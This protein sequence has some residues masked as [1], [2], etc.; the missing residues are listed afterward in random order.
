MKRR[1][2]VIGIILAAILAFASLGFAAWNMMIDHG[3]TE[4]NFTAYT[5]IDLE[6][7]ADTSIRAFDYK[8]TGFVGENQYITSFSVIFD[9]KEKSEEYSVIITLD[10]EDNFIPSSGVSIT[11]NGNTINNTKSITL[12]GINSDRLVTITYTITTQATDWSETGPIYMALDAGKII[13]L[14]ANATSSNGTWTITKKIELITTFFNFIQISMPEQDTTVY[15]YNGAQQT[16]AVPSSSGYTVTNNVRTDA[17]TQTVVISLNDG[18]MWSDETLDDLEYTFVINPSIITITADNKTATYGDSAPTYTYTQS[19]SLYG[20]DTLPSI[21]IDNLSCTCTYKK[22]DAAQNYVIEFASIQ[23]SINSNYQ[24][25]YVNGQLLVDPLSIGSN[26]YP[27]NDFFFT[28][29]DDE[30]TYN[31]TY[32]SPSISISYNDQL[33]TTTQKE[34]L[35]VNYLNNKNAGQ[36]TITITGSGNYA[37]LRTFNFTINKANISIIKTTNNDLSFKS[38][39]RSWDSIKSSIGDILTFD[40]VISGDIVNIAVNGMHNG[41]FAYGKN[42][43]NTNLA[44]TKY[45]SE[46]LVS[47]TNVVGS[48]YLVY[49]SISGSSSSNYNLLTPTIVIKYKTVLV[50]SASF[51]DSS[52]FYTIEDAIAQ[53]SAIYFPGDS[54]GTSSYVYSSFCALNNNDRPNET[55]YN[56]YNSDSKL[57]E[58]ALSKK[59]LVPYKQSTNEK[60]TVNSAA[61]GNVY[62]ALYIPKVISVTFNSGGSL[63]AAAY[64]GGNQSVTETQVGNR[65]VIMNDGLLVFNSNSTMTSY[66]FTMGNGE[67]VLNNSSTAMDCLSVFDWPGGSAASNSEFHSNCFPMAAY[68]VHNIACK[69]II[70]SGAVYQ[71][72]FSFVISVVGPKSVTLTILGTTNS[73][74]LFKPTA[75]NSANYVIKTTENVVHQ[76]TRNLQTKANKEIDIIEIHGSYVDSVLSASLYGITLSSGPSKSMP[77][78]RMRVEIAENSEL[79]LITSDYLFLPGTY[80]KVDNNATLII[81]SGSNDIDVAFV[82]KDSPGVSEKFISYAASNDDAYLLNN[83]KVIV[84]TSASIGGTIKTN[85]VGAILDIQSGGVTADY[86]VSISK[87][88]SAPFYESGSVSANGKTKESDNSLLSPTKYIAIDY[89]NDVCWSTAESSLIYTIEYYDSDKT[90]LIRSVTLSD[91]GVSK[92]INYSDLDSAYKLGYTFDKWYCMSNDTEF[93]QEIVEN[94]D[95]LQLYASWNLTS[96]SINYLFIRFANYPPSG[97]E[98][99]ILVEDGVINPNVNSFSIL[100]GDGTPIDSI[101]FAAASYSEKNQNYIAVNWLKITNVSELNMSNV[102]EQ[103]ITSINSEN[104]LDIAA[105]AETNA[106]SIVIYGIL[107][108]AIDYSISYNLNGGSATNPTTYRVD[109]NTFTLNN[110]TKVGYDFIGWTGTG[111]IEPSMIVTIEKGSSGNRS[112]TA[113]YS[114]IQYSI[115]YYLDG[116]INGNNPSYYTINDS[117]TLRNATKEGYSFA[118]WYDNSSFTGSPITSISDGTTGTINLYAKWMLQ[119]Y[120]ITYINRYLDF[121]YSG[122]ISNNNPTTITR[123]SASYTLSNLSIDGKIFL[124]FFLDEEGNIPITELNYNNVESVLADNNVNIYCLFCASLMNVTIY[125]HNGDGTNTLEFHKYLASNATN[126]YLPISEIV[127]SENTLIN[128]DYRKNDYSFAYLFDNFYKDSAYNVLYDG[129]ISITSGVTTYNIYAKWN[130]KNVLSIQKKLDSGSASTLETIYYYSGQNYKI[131][132]PTDVSGMISG[133]QALV[134]WTLGSNVV[135]SGS[136]QTLS[137]QTTLLADIRTYY[138]ISIG[139]NSYT[140]VTVTLTANQGYT[141]N[142]STKIATAFTGQTL[143]NGSSGIYLTKGSS[144]AAKYTAASS[145]KNN[146]AS[147]SGTSPTTALTTSNQTYTVTGNVT[148]TPAGE[149]SSCVI[150]GT[151]ITLADG[152]QKRVEKIQIGEL[153]RTWNFETGNYSIKPVILIEKQTL[154]DELLTV[155]LSNGQILTMCYGQSFFDRTLKDWIKVYTDNVDDYIG[156]EI[157]VDGDNGATF[158]TIDDYE[159]YIE[160]ATVYELITAFDYNFY[161][162]GIMTA[163]PLIPDGIFFAVDE[164]FKYDE[165]LMMEDIERYGLYTYEEFSNLLT[166]EQFLATNT[167]YWKIAVE[168]GYCDE[169]YVYEV[170]SM[171]LGLEHLE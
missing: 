148:I 52:T 11:C 76:V 153:L 131:P 32:Y 69:T 18:Y 115:N 134:S 3:E 36:A 98:D 86:Q 171:F 78:G 70:N 108:E 146:S 125:V 55:N 25:N 142:T 126:V 37:G 128:S 27:N 168:K 84:K 53:S 141:V 124:G 94:E 118:G 160:E 158:A 80:L 60:E 59:I 17:G 81:G 113:N 96:Y 129:N 19:G 95:V 121:S 112:Y 143:T 50:G 10:D 21:G 119:E 88:T 130:N 109:T 54:S 14:K 114:P 42:N 132:N 67:I 48:T 46:T 35:E 103:R 38:S 123:E 29:Y 89:N 12:E 65:G 163:T 138:S 16:Y 139:T 79:S 106:N 127:D 116:G 72:F 44:G 169:S 144:F 31:G 155:Y 63:V 22:W 154:M 39:I 151:L 34:G 73:S 133:S 62:S 82:T 23:N 43:N 166:Y 135:T 40:S 85:T 150:E 117:I 7:T 2:F 167:P 13:N 122:S 51:S 5:I 149:N 83:G 170:I 66:G 33:L 140:T 8:K 41:H 75:V 45:F 157:M 91:D 9:L 64:I 147:I 92:T 105:E 120:S 99:I 110:P 97:V 161:A 56:K 136:N 100:K 90:T 162:N 159:I 137:N 156:H 49:L 61:S 152:T 71:A 145:S 4:G 164:N 26:V 24:V 165:E 58:F 74:C 57:F 15:T 111:L 87:T 6:D 102:L 20:S 101:V 68:T 104:V 77:I 47:E 30:Y 28:G 107:T 93:V 1:I